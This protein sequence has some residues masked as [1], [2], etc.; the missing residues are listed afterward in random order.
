MIDYCNLKILTLI[1]HFFCTYYNAVSVL[2]TLILPLLI[3]Y[4]I[5]ETLE[6]HVLFIFG[7]NSFCLI[8][9]CISLT[10]SV[11]S[12]AILVFASSLSDV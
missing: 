1:Q 8:F 6:R 2:Y 5:Q 3:K 4:K 12:D 10:N 9:N 11:V 7:K